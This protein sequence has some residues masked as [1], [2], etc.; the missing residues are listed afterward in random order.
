VSAAPLQ[1]PPFK[2]GCTTPAL[3]AGLKAARDDFFSA[4]GADPV[5]D[6]ADAARDKNVQR[7]AVGTLY[8]AANS[9]RSLAPALD[10][11][12]DLIP[13]VGEGLLTIQGVQAAHAFV[14]AYKASIDNCYKHK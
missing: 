8:V 2:E 12:A 4:P 6:A 13:Y 11:F 10:F 14:G 5:G 9:A 1:P 7:A 3:R